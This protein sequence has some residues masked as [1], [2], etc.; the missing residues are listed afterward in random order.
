MSV[1]V[2]AAV[3]LFSAAIFKKWIEL[4]LLIFREELGADWHIK[5]AII[6]S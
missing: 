5:M 4:S 2:N 1:L 6:G 3:S